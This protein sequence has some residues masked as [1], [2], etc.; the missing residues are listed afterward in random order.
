MTPGTQEHRLD[1]FRIFNRAAD[2]IEK[3]SDILPADEGRHMT[4]FHLLRL[5]TRQALDR[6]S[7]VQN[8]SIGVQ[9]RDAV[10]CVLDERAKAI[11]AAAKLFTSGRPTSELGDHPVHPGRW[12]WVRDLLR[13]LIEG[14]GN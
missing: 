14:I 7:L 5:I 4:P 13:R 8:Q 2:L 1:F 3:R 10:G 11:M 6:R 12:G 9:D